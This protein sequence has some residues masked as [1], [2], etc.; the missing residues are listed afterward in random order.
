MDRGATLLEREHASIRLYVFSPTKEERRYQ[1]QKEKLSDRSHTLSE[2][3]VTVAEVF[4][5]EQGWIG[6]EELSPYNSEELRRQYRITP[7]QFK[8]VLVSDSTI[9]MCAESC[10]SCEEL[11]MRIENEPAE[12][13]HVF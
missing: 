3:E 4:E 13:K 8:V 10:I 2:H 11:F 12:P 6:N 7:G 1:L 5:H 9:I